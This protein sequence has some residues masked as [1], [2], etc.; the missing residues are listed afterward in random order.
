MEA[1]IVDYLTALGWEWGVLW[2]GGIKKK[3]KWTHGHR[4]QCGDW[5]GW[6]WRWKESIRINGNGK[7][8]IKINDK[9]HKTLCGH[10]RPCI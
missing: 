5:E 8:T 10:Y 2:G 6:G 1:T 3:R 9:K 7:N 4:S